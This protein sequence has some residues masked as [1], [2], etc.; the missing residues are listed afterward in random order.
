MVVISER[1]HYIMSTNLPEPV[2]SLSSANLESLIRRV[3]REELIRLLRT[4]VRSI[5]DDWEQEGRDDPEGDETLLIE[6]LAVLQEH[7]DK[8][9]HWMS[10]EDF[11]TELD[12][13]E[14]RG[15]LPN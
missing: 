7:G 3:V 5:L 10:W 2:I 8:P 14:A 4:P 9:E 11:E 13:A 12:E 15:E 6:A 1:S